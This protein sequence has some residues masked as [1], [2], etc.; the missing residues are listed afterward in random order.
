MRRHRVRI[1]PAWAF[2]LGLPAA[3]GGPVEAQELPTLADVVR[4][5]SDLWGEAALRQ[6]G[7]PSY[8]FFAKLLPPPRYVHADFRHYPIVL[9]A[10]GAARKARLIANGSGVNLRG[11]SRSWR[12]VGL[13]FTFRVGPDEFR[14]G[15]LRDR[16]GEPTLAGGYLP[17]VTIDYRHPSPVQ[18]DGL[19]PIDQVRADHAEEVYRLEAFVSTDPELAAHA[20]VLVRFTLA[21]GDAGFI[22]VEPEAGVPVTFEPGMLRDDRGR[23]LARFDESWK[24]ERQA[25]HARLAPG[26]AATVAIATVP[27]E[28]GSGFAASASTYQ[29][30]RARACQAWD[31]ILGRGMS[32]DVPEPYVNDAWRNLILQNFMLLNGDRMFYSAGN[33]Y[34]QLYEA[35]GSDA[36]LT[37]L[38]WGHEAEA[39]RMLIPL[40]DFTRKGLEYHQ[41]GTKLNDVIGYYW[42]ARDAEFVRAERPRWAKEVARIVDS[43][44][45]GHGLLPREQYC[46]DIKTPVL[47]L[48]SN[49]KAWR[50][51]HDLAPLLDELGDGAEAARL[52]AAAGELRAH[53]LA[54]LETSLRRET[55]PPFVPI[56]LLADESIHD[57]VT[58]TRIGSY[59]N[60]VIN[61][62][63][64]SNLFPGDPG[65]AAWI[66]HYLEEHGGLCMGMTRAGG[67]QPTFWTSPQRINP[68]YGTRYVIDALR[69]DDAGR[70]LV[71]FYGMLAQGF[72][73][74]TFVAGEGCDLTPVDPGGRFFYCPPNSAGNA[75][76]LA[77]LRHLLIQDLDLDDDGRPETLR[78]LFATPPRW[79]ENGRSIRVDRA[80]TAFGP[81]SL[82]IESGLER[83]EVLA[84]LDLPTRNPPDA[85]LLR[86]RVPE[87]WRVTEA[88]S[89]DRTFAVDPR[90]TAALSGLAG[91]SVVRFRVRKDD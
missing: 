11:G 24:W 4:S 86:A 59:W 69:R 2:L 54:A 31:E 76:F 35:E 78:L 63:I 38:A 40:L 41:S 73:R 53:L 43:R 30:Q 88:R 34:E 60:L 3:P 85:V 57:P 74:N 19:V 75:H 42:Q 52:R 89:G 66:P 87:G 71:S 37:M 1:H 44:D 14:F 68:L 32:V 26:T 36:A 33:Q 46:G 17:I 15:E 56:A 70:A 23:A 65:R 90:G 67:A 62:V 84:E 12:E 72:T 80:P 18:A 81:M 83:G 25:A 49:A 64:G 55:S 27:L 47:S 16:L 22:T 79:L 5:G 45:A 28:A 48:S 8:E 10:P 77:M 39:R 51:L 20:V 61:Y 91:K 29:G 13:P 6:P 21:A 58:A 9:S 50:A 82:R 7:G